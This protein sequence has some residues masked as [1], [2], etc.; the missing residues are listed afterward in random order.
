MK[1]CRA[2]VI[3]S[4]L[5]VLLPRVAGA[6]LSNDQ[7]EAIKDKYRPVTVLIRRPDGGRGTG[8]VI[9]RKPIVVATCVHV[10]QGQSE[11][12]VTHPTF[13][14]EGD[15]LRARKAFVV[16]DSD[17]ALLLVEGE[18]DEWPA[19]V[20]WRPG[21]VPNGDV[22]LFGYAT[23]GYAEET[24]LRVM[25]ASVSLEDLDDPKVARLRIPTLKVIELREGT[26]VPGMSG[27]AVVDSAGTLLA[28]GAGTVTQ[29]GNG[30]LRHF[31]IPAGAPFDLSQLKPLPKNESDPYDGAARGNG[32]VR[33]R[34]YVKQAVTLVDRRLAADALK[35]AVK[36]EK[37]VGSLGDR[38]ALPRAMNDGG[39]CGAYYV[40]MR[41][42][43]VQEALEMK[44]GSEIYALETFAG[45]LEAA[46]RRS[47]GSAAI[48]A[49]AN[50]ADFKNKTIRETFPTFCAKYVDVKSST[51]TCEIAYPFESTATIRW[52]DAAKNLETKNKVT[53]DFIRMGF[54][55]SNDQL[56]SV[57]GKWIAPVGALVVS[58]STPGAV[59]EYVKTAAKSSE[60][61]GKIL[62]DAGLASQYALQSSDG[63]QFALDVAANAVDPGKDDPTLATRD[64]AAQTIA[65]VQALREAE[66]AILSLPLDQLPKVPAPSGRPPKGDKA[67][68]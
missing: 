36:I 53:A 16:K 9:Q 11:V 68:R 65:T 44:R 6:A 40:A 2:M 30:L 58:P 20:D 59:A 13:T 43:L 35:C 19:S 39:S 17:I 15:H 33:S 61:T 24:S 10:V 67:Q 42:L 14:G 5:A 41:D 27:C 63:K 34:A 26:F 1:S 60:I 29:R 28:L 56:A 3:A 38:E 37:F 51:G 7:V 47:P 46:A 22:L 32:P 31:A 12:Y 18:I 64:A 45:P 66:R 55:I 57:E 49:A 48:V 52:K 21:T 50:D 62:I 8:I 4:A 54:F 25:Q 23:T